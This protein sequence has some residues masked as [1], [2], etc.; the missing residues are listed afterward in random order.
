MMNTN[1][2]VEMWKRL[3]LQ[4]ADLHEELAQSSAIYDIRLHNALSNVRS[5][6]GHLELARGIRD[7]ITAIEGIGAEK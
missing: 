4:E 3:K 6:L 1:E 5:R 2:Y 7:Q